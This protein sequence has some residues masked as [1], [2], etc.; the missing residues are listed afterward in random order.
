MKIS[1]NIVRD[2]L[3]LYHDKVASMESNEMVNE[4]LTECES[5][6][7]YYAK[8]CDQKKSNRI[9]ESYKQVKKKNTKRTV[10]IVIAVVCALV[11]PFLMGAVIIGVLLFSEL[12]PVK[13]V[14]ED[15]SEYRLY[16]TGEQAVDLYQGKWDMDESI[17][18]EEIEE[19]MQVQDYKMV[20]YNPWDEQYLGYLVVDYT[21]ED[22]QNEVA[23]LNEYES[24]PYLGY[25]GVT[26]F[27]DYE[28]LAMYADSYNGFV[29]ALTDGEDTIVYVELIFCN[30]QID[31]NYHEYIPEE[32]LPEGFDASPNNAY[33]K[34][35]MKKRK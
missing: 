33:Q 7:A 30:Y 4:H 11:I 17:W 21:K 1:C 19:Q 23:R 10:L 8:M 29:Y 14:H 20:Y 24:T 34:M 18:P 3:P 2:L 9:V 35:M 15:V 16:R 25:Y 27:E 32:Y 28:L 13:E 31:L 5:C 26:G 12:F 22:Y 6:K